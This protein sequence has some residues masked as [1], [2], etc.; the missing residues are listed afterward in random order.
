MQATQENIDNE[1]KR[2]GEGIQ[3]HLSS[4]FKQYGTG[5]PFKTIFPKYGVKAK[6][7]G[8][9]INVFSEKIAELGYIKIFHSPTGKRMIFAGDCPLTEA[10]MLDKIQ[11]E[12]L[13]EVAQKEASKLAR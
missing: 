13:I 3:S 4:F 11:E 1:L 8:M 12:Y 2:T 5:L 6:N 7:I 9:D 10:E